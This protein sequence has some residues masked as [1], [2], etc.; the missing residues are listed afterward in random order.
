MNFSCRLLSHWSSVS[1]S[2]RPPGLL[3]AHVT[4]M[5]TCPSASIAPA[6]VRSTSSWTPMSPGNGS[7]VPPVASLS[8]AATLVRR[9]PSRAV[10]ATSQPSSARIR[11]V[12]RPIPL[13]PPVTIAFEPANP[14]SISLLCSPARSLDYEQ[15]V[16]IRHVRQEVESILI[17][18]D[19]VLYLK[20]VG[21]RYEQHGIGAEDHAGLEAGVAISPYVGLLVDEEADAVAHE[22]HGIPAQFPEPLRDAAV[23]LRAARAATNRPEDEVAAIH[24]ACPDLLGARGWLADHGGAADSGVVSAEHAEHLQ[25]D[26]VSWPEL[27]HGRADVGKLAALATAEDEPLE[28]VRPVGEELRRHGAG[29]VHLGVA[30]MDALERLLDRP[31][32]DPGEAAHEL[33]L[34]RRLRE[35]QAVEERVR[36]PP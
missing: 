32:G 25:A 5:S 28:V 22:A 24:D 11:A 21:T 26:E 10:M 33:D 36:R 2:R 35:P 7:T 9:S 1:P 12:S 8:S 19:D 17:H 18:R 27:A 16:C 15:F 29:Q 34:T 23:D 6:I 4:R 31:V 30:R 20:S 14:R 3:P 13:L